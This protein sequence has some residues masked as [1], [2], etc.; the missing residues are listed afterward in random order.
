VVALGRRGC[1]RHRDRAPEHLQTILCRGAVPGISS[2][3]EVVSTRDVQ[4]RPSGVHPFLLAVRFDE[5]TERPILERHNRSAVFSGK[6]LSVADDAG[7]VQGT[8]P[9]ACQASGT[10]HGRQMTTC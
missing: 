6:R 3:R 4:A 10:S 1:L 7:W 8:L 9:N 5:A 2:G